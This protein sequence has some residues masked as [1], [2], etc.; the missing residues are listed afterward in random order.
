MVV[1]LAVGNLERD[2]DL[3]KEGRERER[4]EITPGIEPQAIDPWRRRAGVRHQRPL[5]AVRIRLS[6]ADQLPSRFMLTLEDDL[7][8]SGW[9]AAR[10]IEDVGGDGAHGSGFYR[11][12][13]GSRVR[14]AHQAMLTQ[15]QLFSHRTFT[16]AASAEVA[17]TVSWGTA[18]RQTLS[19]PATSSGV[20]VP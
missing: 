20:S 13:A 14:S 10:R 16:R 18:P 5:P 4:F 17:R 7:D 9:N 15:S 6:T 19:P 8:T 1:G 12:F 3:R 11:G 2:G